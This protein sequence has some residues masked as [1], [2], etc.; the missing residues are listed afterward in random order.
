MILYVNKLIIKIQNGKKFK[1]KLN[2]KLW[3]K[4][5]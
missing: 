3:Q 4:V 1:Q 5:K 2:K